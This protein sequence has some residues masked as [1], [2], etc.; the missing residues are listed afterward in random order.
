MS[1]VAHHIQTP[2][3]NKLINVRLVIIF[4]RARR[5]ILIRV[6]RQC[7]AKETEGEREREHHASQLEFRNQQ[8]SAGGQCDGRAN[9]KAKVKKKKNVATTTTPTTAK[10]RQTL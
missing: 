3:G 9:G 2:S 7:D 10:K 1:L 8:L 4:A 5:I 6:H